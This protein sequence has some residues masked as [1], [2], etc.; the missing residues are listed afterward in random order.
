MNRFDLDPQEA[1]EDAKKLDEKAT[2]ERTSYTGG[3]P[4]VASPNSRKS[5]ATKTEEMPAS[6]EDT[7]FDIRLR[8]ILT[9]DDPLGRALLERLQSMP[10]ASRRHYSTSKAVR[11]AVMQNLKAIAKDI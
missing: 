11:Y 5:K 7:K 6:E 8:L 2:E 4:P 9:E 1:Y 3:S 10:E